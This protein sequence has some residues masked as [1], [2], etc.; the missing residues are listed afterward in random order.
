M[1]LDAESLK[2]FRCGYGAG[3]IVATVEMSVDRQA[4]LS[5]GGTN[6][7]EDLLIAVE[8][9]ASPVPGDLGEEAMLDGVPFRSAGGVVGYG[10]SEAVG[11]SQLGLEFCFPS[12]ATITVTAAGIAEDEELSRARIAKRSLL[13]PPMGDG[14][15]GEGGCVMGDA[16]HNGAPIGEQIINAV[17]DGDAGGVGAEVVIV[18]QAGRQ[19]PTGTGI[20]EMADE[21]ALLGIDANDRETTALESVAKVS[22]VEKLMVAIGTMVGGKLLVIDAQRIAQ[23]ME[24]AGDGVGAHPDPEVSERHGDLG[25]GSPRPLQ[26][27]DGIPGGI[28]FEQELDQ[29][30]DV[31]VFF[32]TGLRPP[33]T[34]RV[35]PGVTF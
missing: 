1:G 2:L 17:R 7:V 30:E 14:V 16:D 11:I 8:R 33:P 34:W 13:A 23:V 18:D 10:K 28:V 27:G 29:G 24:Q 35:R 20:S 26:A 19:V 22:E 25:G 6:K 3:E 15:S 31:G 5:S 32:S 12:A 4:G 9:F 21:L